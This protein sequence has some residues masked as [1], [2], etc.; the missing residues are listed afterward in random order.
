VLAQ[1]TPFPYTQIPTLTLLVTNYYYYYMSS[2]LVA[3]CFSLSL[4]LPNMQEN[5]S[6]QTHVQHVFASQQMRCKVGDTR[7]LHLY[8]SKL[9]AK[10]QAQ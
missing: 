1:Q 7:N 3:T 2:L 4:Y 9:I 6:C 5:T 10:Q 8:V